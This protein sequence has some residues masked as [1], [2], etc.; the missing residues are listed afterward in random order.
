MN[1]KNDTKVINTE[2]RKTTVK[3]LKI[4]FFLAVI[5]GIPVFLFIAVPDF[6]SILTDREAFRVFMSEHSRQGVVFYLFIQFIQVIIGFLPGQI[7]QFVGGYLFGIVLGLILSL[8]GTGIGTLTVFFLARHFGRE[9]VSLFV[10]DKNLNKF[11]DMM[12]SG[13]GYTIVI[14]IYLIPGLPKDVFT[15]AAGLTRLRP[16]TFT[17]LT[18]IARAPAMLATILF[19][20]FLY[21]GNYFGVLIIIVIIATLLVIILIKRKSLFSFIERLHTKIR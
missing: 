2:K 4:V 15:Y 13:K 8:I 5:V 18:V 7:I 16:L 6:G 3:W 17:I 20:R 10:K 19:S 12:D 1:E 9:F 11:I 14:L 21:T